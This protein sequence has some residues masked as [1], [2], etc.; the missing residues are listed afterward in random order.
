M[1]SD[2]YN[3]NFFSRGTDNGIIPYVQDKAA[4]YLPEPILLQLDN[5]Q[6]F[7]K[8]NETGPSLGTKLFDRISN[9]H[10]LAAKGLSYLPEFNKANV[11]YAL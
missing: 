8:K 2:S 11:V 10:P 3:A 1:S 9:L 6:S 4:P 5:L 7:L